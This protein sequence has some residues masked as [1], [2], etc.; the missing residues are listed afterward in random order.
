MQAGQTGTSKTALTRSCL[1]SP[2]ELV[3]GA[4]H[5]RW[6]RGAHERVVDGRHRF[7][8]PFSGEFVEAIDGED[9]VVVLL[10]AAAI[11]IRRDVAHDEICGRRVAGQQPIIAGVD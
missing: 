3:R 11:E 6:M 8:H 2:Y 7:N 9:N 4:L 1:R 10:E 5:F